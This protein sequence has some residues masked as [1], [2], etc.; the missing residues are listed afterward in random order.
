MLIPTLNEA[1]RIAATLAAAQQAFGAR[2][3][4]I[5]SDG[6]SRDDTALIAEAA[7]ARVLHAS[8]GRGQQLDAA[9]REARGDICIFLHADTLL[10]A[11]AAHYIERAATRGA[12]GGAFL[13][14]F[15]ERPLPLLLLLWKQAINLRSRLAGVATG[16]QA[17]FARREVLLRLG[18]VPHLAL[19]EDVHLWRTLK[20][21]GRLSV[22]P[23]SVRTS[24]RLW[25]E[26]GA[27]RG[28]LLHL[29]LRALHALGMSPARL[30]RMYPTSAS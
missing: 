30:A 16:D 9:L 6:G 1:E 24:A 11:A 5:V 3:E 12:I 14:D 13:L 17:I 21:A 27:L 15:G 2:A 8:R 25:L 10:P 18:G 7:G 23:A 19:F 29:R 4:Y 26:N 22:M 20:R 28:I